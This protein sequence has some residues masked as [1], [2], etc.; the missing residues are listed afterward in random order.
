M[1][2]CELCAEQPEDGDIL[3]HLRRMHP[4]DYGEGPICWPDGRV[5]IF[6]DAVNNPGDITGVDT[7]T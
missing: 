7:N 6:D 4:D 2:T 3:D 5:V 1:A